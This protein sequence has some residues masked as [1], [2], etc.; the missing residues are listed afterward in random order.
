MD[1]RFETFL[2]A[3]NDLIDNA[4]YQLACAIAAKEADPGE[5]ALEWDMSYI[6]EIIDA[7]EQILKG[8]GLRH[9]YPFY[10]RGDRTPCYRGKDCAAADCPLKSNFDIS[11]AQRGQEITAEQYESY[12]SVLPPISLNGG[13]DCWAGFQLGEPYCHERD[14]R[15]GQF[16]PTYATF[17]N[18]GNRCFYQGINFAGEVDSRPYMENYPKAGEVLE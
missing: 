3:K 6:G 18:R 16:R 17:T 12:L 4:A 1:G 14:T 15:T 5:K 10:E 11:T 7:A 2:T 8:H 9:C 13:Q